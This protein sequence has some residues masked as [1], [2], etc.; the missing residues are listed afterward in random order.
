MCGCSLIILDLRTRIEE[1]LE[2]IYTLLYKRESWHSEHLW[3]LLKTRLAGEHQNQEEILHCCMLT[4][5]GNHVGLIYV[6]WLI[7][8]PAQIK[9]S[10]RMTVEYIFTF[11]WE[12]LLNHIGLI[13]G[14]WACA[15]CSLFH[16]AGENVIIFQEIKKDIGWAVSGTTAGTQVYCFGI[17]EGIVWC[18]A[19]PTPGI[20]K[21]FV[22]VR[23]NKWSAQWRWTPY[24]PP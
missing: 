11:L 23:M 5:V 21:M 12:Y 10:C 2:V 15:M 14:L 4:E 3:D 22:N 19:M 1:A 9:I 17:P 8:Y 16:L 6:L 20:P 24:V 7:L 18:S 13:T